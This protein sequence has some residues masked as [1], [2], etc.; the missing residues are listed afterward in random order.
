MVPDKLPSLSGSWKSGRVDVSR[1]ARSTIL[2]N[3]FQLESGEH[4]FLGRD[5]SVKGS[6][7]WVD[8]HIEITLAKDLRFSQDSSLEIVSSV[9]A[10]H[11]NG[12]IFENS[13]TIMAALI[14]GRLA[15]YGSFHNK[16]NNF[17]T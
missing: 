3:S 15:F 1:S 5:T 7:L 12:G 17:S 8:T 13:G 4:K 11:S 16:G 9:V 2:V 14:Q 10:I 6:S